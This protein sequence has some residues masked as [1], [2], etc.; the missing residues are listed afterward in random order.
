MKSEQEVKWGYLRETREETS[1]RDPDDG[2]PR[3]ALIDYLLAIF[4]DTKEEDWIHNKIVDSIP[5]SIRRRFRPDYRN[6][7]KRLII[8][9]D[10]PDHF[11]NVVRI[12]SDQEGNKY[13]IENGYTVIR[14]PYF[15]QLTKTVIKQLFAVEMN[16][17]MFPEGIDSIRLDP[18]YQ[19]TPYFLPQEGIVRMAKE[20]IKCPEQYEVN[21]K[22]MKAYER[23]G[24][25]GWERLE[26]EYSKLK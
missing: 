4:P 19:Q 5:K 12:Q 1:Q 14:T 25:V 20:F 16:E 7:E 24:N 2:L 17:E 22:A 21:M 23:Q 3:T 9:F 10:G 18:R 13:Y 15:I 6:E 11:R 26:E 8:E